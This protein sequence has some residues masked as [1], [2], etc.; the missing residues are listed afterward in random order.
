MLAGA[1]PDLTPKCLPIRRRHWRCRSAFN[2][3]DDFSFKPGKFLALQFTP[4]Q[5]THILAHARISPALDLALHKR[6]QFW[7]QCNIHCIH[8]IISI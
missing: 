8:K 7:G 6:S 3:L 2:A 4:D 1:V 5:L